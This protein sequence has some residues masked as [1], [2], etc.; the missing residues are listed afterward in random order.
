M[1]A[2]GTL[3]CQRFSYLGKPKVVGELLVDVVAGMV[4]VDFADLA[5]N[6]DFLT[7]AVVADPV[8]VCMDT[9]LTTRQF[10]FSRDIPVLVGL[11]SDGLDDA[12]L[13]EAVLAPQK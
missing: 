8:N 3:S 9:A 5:I 4:A 12:V 13:V 10:F 2:E 1:L 11:L 6:D 7:E